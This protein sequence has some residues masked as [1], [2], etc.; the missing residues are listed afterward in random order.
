MVTKRF[1]TSLPEEL[2]NFVSRQVHV[3]GFASHSDYVRHILRKEMLSTKGEQVAWINEELRL[4]EESGIC[5][6]TPDQIRA[7][8][9][10]VIKKASVKG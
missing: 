9:R 5:D 4:S 10:E 2:N 8:L 7:G 6:E 3:G 1:N